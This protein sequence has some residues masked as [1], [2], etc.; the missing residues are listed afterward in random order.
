M[1]SSGSVHAIHSYTGIT[2][3]RETLA[4]YFKE[5]YEH[6]NPYETC[7]SK[8]L[9]HPRQARKTIKEPCWQ[10]MTGPSKEFS[11]IKKFWT[12]NLCDGQ[13]DTASQTEW[14]YQSSSDSCIYGHNNA[15]SMS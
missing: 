5:E 12:N 9:E 3:F 4:P 13:P 6:N 10:V 2:V 1:Q 14:Y 15:A 11:R 8:L 7:K